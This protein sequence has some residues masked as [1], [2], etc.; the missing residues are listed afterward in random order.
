MRPLQ[1][2]AV[3][4]RRL[5]A[6]AAASPVR[7]A[8]G[9]RLSAWL[10]DRRN[11]TALRGRPPLR[12]DRRRPALRRGL[13][14]SPPGP[15]SAWHAGYHLWLGWLGEDI[16]RSRPRRAGRPNGAATSDD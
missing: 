7:T 9:A 11:R 1:P 10:P 15:R 16:A 13:L 6:G 12:H 14:R 5:P 8:A 4:V 2:A 3:E